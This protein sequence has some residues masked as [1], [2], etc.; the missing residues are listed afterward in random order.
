MLD[1]NK[2]SHVIRYVLI[3]LIFSTLKKL[4]FWQNCEEVLNW[5]NSESWAELH[6]GHILGSQ[7]RSRDMSRGEV[8]CRGH[9]SCPKWFAFTNRWNSN[10]ANSFR[11]K[12]S[13][14]LE[15]RLKAIKCY[16]RLLY[17]LFFLPLA[18]SLSLL[19]LCL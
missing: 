8:A 9:A 16:E 10:S 11:V 2:K 3:L 5:L 12:C 1:V 14:Q 19:P 17:Y 13:C 4:R 15:I 7:V 6:K 18:Y